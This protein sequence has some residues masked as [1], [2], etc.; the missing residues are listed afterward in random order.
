M[1]FDNYNESRDRFG[2]KWTE[3]RNIFEAEYSSNLVKPIGRNG[4]V[5][6]DLGILAKSRH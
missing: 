5:E 2:Q 6:G 4:T 3:D 1:L